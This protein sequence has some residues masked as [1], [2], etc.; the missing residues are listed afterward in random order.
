ML[1]ALS[2]TTIERGYFRIILISVEH[3]VNRTW[4]MFSDDGL[5]FFG[6]SNWCVARQRKRTNTCVDQSSHRW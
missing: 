4:K 6:T 5:N 3:I 1:L 2:T